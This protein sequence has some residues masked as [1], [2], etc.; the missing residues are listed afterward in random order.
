MKREQIAKFFGPEWVDFMAPFLQSEEFN[1]IL[2][3]LKEEKAAGKAIFPEQAKMFRAFSELPL[4]QVRVVIIGQDPYPIEGYANGLAFAH[5]MTKK[6]AP[7]LDKMI[8]CIEKDCYDGLNFD[9]N[10]FDTELAT[11]P[12]QGVLLLNAALTVVKDTPESHAE[13]WRKFTQYVINTLSDT[14][15]NLIF[16][17]WGKKASAFIENIHFVKHFTFSAEHPALA[18]R[19]KRSWNCKHFSLTNA[20]IMG[21]QLGEPIKW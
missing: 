16:L 15:R 4:S 8:D 1:V 21:N 17:A 14:R 9:K 7:S 11:W 3:A 19:E 6:I 5:P 2:N 18:A 20:T 12:A 10:K 13:I